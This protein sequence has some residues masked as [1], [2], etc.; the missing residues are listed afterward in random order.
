MLLCVKWWVFEE[1]VE[2][3]GDVALEAA[4]GF[5]WC[6]AFGDAA[7]DVGAG[8]FVAAGAGDD[9]G[10]QGAVQSPVAAPAEPVAGLDLAGG[11]FDRGDPAEA[12]ERGV[13]AAAALM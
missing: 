5:A 1:A 3:A 7:G 2:V 10:V 9:D 6:L 4:A 13:A 11:R 8:G 12:S